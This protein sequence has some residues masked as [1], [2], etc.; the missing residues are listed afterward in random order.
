MNQG[1]QV[2]PSVTFVVRWSGDSKIVE[3]FAEHDFSFSEAPWNDS[4]NGVR[5]RHLHA[6]TRWE[7]I[8]KT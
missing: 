7:E 6:L 8:K 3:A 4:H 2:S 1:V 5:G